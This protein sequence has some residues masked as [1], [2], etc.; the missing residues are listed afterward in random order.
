MPP[1]LYPSGVKKNKIPRGPECFDAPPAP[2]ASATEEAEHGA[3]RVSVRWASARDGADD[4][5]GATAY[6]GAGENSADAINPPLPG[7][8]RNPHTDPRDPGGDSIDVDVDVDGE[9]AKEGGKKNDLDDVPVSG[10]PQASF[11]A[12]L[13]A[14]LASASDPRAATPASPSTSLKPLLKHTMSASQEKTPP[15]NKDASS[16]A[17]RPFLRRGDRQRRVAD[18]AK[19]KRAGEFVS[20]PATRSSTRPAADAGEAK[21]L[22]LIHI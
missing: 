15:A 10:A 22:S 4:V 8:E 9:K 6:D 7:S 18:D 13:E 14:S 20:A 19:A 17:P 3:M 21:R 2:E 1:D 12:L 11:D 5:L 16:A